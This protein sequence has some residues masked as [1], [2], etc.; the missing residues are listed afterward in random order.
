[1]FYLSLAGWI[2]GVF[3]VAAVGYIA[4][5]CKGLSLTSNVCLVD[6]KGGKHKLDLLLSHKDVHPN[7]AM[8][9]MNYLL[10]YRPP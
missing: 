4:E 3:A 7:E 9:C 6:H 1:M 8:M 2:P 5:S 10:A